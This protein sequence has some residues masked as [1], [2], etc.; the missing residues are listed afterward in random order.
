MPCQPPRSTQYRPAH[1]VADGP[2]GD[3]HAATCRFF[4]FGLGRS[5]IFHT[6]RPPLTWIAVAMALV[7]RQRKSAS[8]SPSP[9]ASYL[10][11]TVPTTPPGR[12]H[13]RS[14]RPLVIPGTTAAYYGTPNHE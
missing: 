6:Q 9:R 1:D 12:I 4:G 7:R 13:L 5:L 3:D 2:V 11:F 14:A 10:I 8:P